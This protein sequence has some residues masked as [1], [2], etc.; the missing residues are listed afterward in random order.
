[1][2]DAQRGCRRTRFDPDFRL[3]DRRE[4]AFG[5]NHEFYQIELSISNKLIEVI[6]AD[7]PHDLR[8]TAI[9]LIA[10]CLNDAGDAAFQAP[11]RNGLS[12]LYFAQRPAFA[13]CEDDVH[14]QDVVD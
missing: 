4:T 10:V 7:A 9:D 12:E 5:S 1:M 11:A 13:G 3:M 6:A 2:H 8:E 14:F